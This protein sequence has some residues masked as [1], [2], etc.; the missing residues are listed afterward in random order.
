M[1]PRLRKYSHLLV[2][3]RRNNLLDRWDEFSASGYDDYASTFIADYMINNEA[4]AA[5]MDVSDDSGGAVGSIMLLD[6]EDGTLLYTDDSAM[7][8]MLNECIDVM[9]VVDQKKYE[10]RSAEAIG[11]DLRMMHW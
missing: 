10:E 3:F 9:P 6:N 4:Q 1:G 11:D 8:A 7:E 2:A 5:C